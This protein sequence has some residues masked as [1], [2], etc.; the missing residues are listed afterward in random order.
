VGLRAVEE[1]EVALKE[2]HL[3]ARLRLCMS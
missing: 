3:A 2:G 1:L